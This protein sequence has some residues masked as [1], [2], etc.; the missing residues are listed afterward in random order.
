MSQRTK[1]VGFERSCQPQGGPPF[2]AHE[3]LALPAG[4]ARRLLDFEPAACDLTPA[5]LFDPF[6]GPSVPRARTRHYLPAPKP[7][8]FYRLR[9]LITPAPQE[10]IG[11]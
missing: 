2:Y 7:A 6:G 8:A 11:K 5:A 3:V 10:E 9:D 4:M 1:V